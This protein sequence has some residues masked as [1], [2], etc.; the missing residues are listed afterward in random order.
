[1]PDARGETKAEPRVRVI[2]GCGY[3]GVAFAER[4][5]GLGWRVIGVRRAREDAAALTARGS[6]LTGL[7]FDDPALPGRLAS[8]DAVLSSIPPT[9]RGDPAL[10]AYSGALDGPK[11]RW[12][13]YLST[14]GVY[15]DRGGGWAFEWDTCAPSSETSR[16]RVDAE[17]GWRGLQQPAHIFRL[18]GIYGPGRSPFE[19]L[20]AGAERRIDKPGQVFSR[21]HR[22]DIVAAL[23]ASLARP[24]PGAIY[25]VCDD[26]PAPSS[27]VAAYAAT[28]IGAPPPPLVAFEDADLSPMAQRFYADNKR[29]SNALIKAELGWRPQYPDYRSG[30]AAVLA[31]E[32]SAQR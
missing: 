31:A 8:A 7:A 27:E 3:V 4:L 30:L 6:G 14:T 1:M 15:G 22:D 28:L 17:A 11:D 5:L 12:I 24:R 2:L 18:P 19:R 13:G 25:N 21:A 32:T 29:V 16:R 10:L 26:Q 23:S 20:R 9:D